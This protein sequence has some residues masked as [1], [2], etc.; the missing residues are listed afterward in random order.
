MFTQSILV[1][2]PTRLRRTVA[3]SISIIP[4]GIG[5]AYPV[6]G[7][8][9]RGTLPKIVGPSSSADGQL[10]E[11]PGNSAGRATGYARRP[12]VWRYA[13]SESAPCR[14]TWARKHGYV[15]INFTNPRVFMQLSSYI[16]NIILAAALPL[17]VGLHAAQVLA[18]AP[19]RVAPL[20]VGSTAPTRALATADGRPLDL[21]Q[22]IA[23]KPTILVFYRA[24]WCS[25][26]NREL[27]ELRES[28]QIYED[29]GFQIIAVSTDTP[30]GLKSAIEK[31][32][33]NYT[34]LSDR[35]LSLSS[36]YGI[37]FRVTKELASSYAKKGILLPSV[38]GEEGAAGLLVPTVFV[39]DGN[40]IIRW[41][42]SNSKRNPTRTQLVAAAV[43]ART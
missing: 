33:P 7:N 19:D 29:L 5:R 22:A 31:N 17:S 24:N 11:T 43:R 37:A 15:H 32:H 12:S 10:K 40:G 20:T 14:S 26:G 16:R 2:F 18:D 4:L 36:A 41:V 35:G 1:Y 23:H 8:A 13:V 38:P 3:G 6:M 27:A 39:V 42:Y 34:L 30:E 9:G 21:G 28:A 25:L